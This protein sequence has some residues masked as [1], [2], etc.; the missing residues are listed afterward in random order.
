MIASTPY[1]ALTHATT[2][3][4][5]RPLITYV[6]PEGRTELSV[7]SFQNGVAKAAGLLRD[8]LDVQPGDL[9]AL[10]LPAHWQTSVWLGA[11][12]AVGA[13]A[14]IRPVS[15]TDAVVVLATADLLPQEQLSAEV[16]R[17]S[18]HPFGLPANDPLPPHVQEAALEVRA[19]GDIFTPFSE[20]TEDQ[21][22]LRLGDNTW[23]NGEV[24]TAATEFAG[25]WGLVS[26][27]RLLTSR[28]LTRTDLAAA[29]A[30]LAVPLS[31]DAATIIAS[32]D[33]PG[34]SPTARLAS[35]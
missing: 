10:L 27:G 3:D 32:G 33:T 14:Q 34:E 6:G 18:R 15:L 29:L 30:L 11:C 26:G 12:W 2:G 31:V 19:H 23:S 25:A 35:A 28:E 22:A 21:P 7:R 13:V 8:G 1:A 16:L 4:A 17:I 24:M 5:A 20:P 9:V